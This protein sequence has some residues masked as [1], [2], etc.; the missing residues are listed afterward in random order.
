MSCN[1]YIFF[2][3]AHGSDSKGN[4]FLEYTLMFALSLT[5]LQS[6]GKERS[7][8]FPSLCFPTSELFKQNQNGYS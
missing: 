7:Y 3:V 8:A 6:M 2:A 1:I 4:G 5:Q